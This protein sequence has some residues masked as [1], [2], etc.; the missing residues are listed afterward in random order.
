MLNRYPQI[1]S[2]FVIKRCALMRIGVYS[3][4][5]RV[6]LNALGFADLTLLSPREE[7]AILR[8]RILRL[9][10]QDFECCIRVGQSLVDVYRIGARI[11]IGLNLCEL[12]DNPIV[13]VHAVDLAALDEQA[14][15]LDRCFY[16]EDGDAEKW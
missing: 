4:D 14:G 5:D 8:E 16:V 12:P 11:S 10:E 9:Q 15:D 13:L 6:L 3:G 2:L 1:C 7:T